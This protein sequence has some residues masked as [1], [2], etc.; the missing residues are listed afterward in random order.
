MRKIYPECTDGDV[1]CGCDP[2]S[3]IPPI[4]HA[5]PMTRRS[6]GATRSVGG[7]IHFFWNSDAVRRDVAAR[8]FSRGGVMRLTGQVR[9]AFPPGSAAPWSRPFLEAVRSGHGGESFGR[10][11]GGFAEAIRRRA[12]YDSAPVLL[13]VSGERLLLRIARRCD[14]IAGAPRRFFYQV[15]GPMGF[16][17]FGPIEVASLVEAGGGHRVCIAS[18]LG[19][20]HV[21]SSATFSLKLRTESGR[22]IPSVSGIYGKSSVGAVKFEFPPSAPQE[23]FV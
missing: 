15:G 17:P 16:A 13:D 22:L 4:T 10:Y 3:L 7:F 19:A 21:E 18:L 9:G 14:D 12:M 6:R 8:V 1:F 23:L 20:P 11:V 2:P 5:F